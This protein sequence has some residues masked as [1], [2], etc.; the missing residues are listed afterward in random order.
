MA[1][2]K[3]STMQYP[4]FEGDIRLEHPE[5]T[6]CQTGDT[7]PCP[8]GFIKVVEVE[9]PT[10]DVT[11]NQYLIEEAPQIINGVWTQIFSVGTYTAEQLSAMAEAIKVAQE[12][13]N[14][15]RPQLPTTKQNTSGSG[16]A[17]NVVA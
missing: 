10:I 14:K 12:L 8:E 15:F 17:P 9:P 13:K 6:E 5:I 7:F 3:L 2:I 1:F 16:S 4:L 11:Q